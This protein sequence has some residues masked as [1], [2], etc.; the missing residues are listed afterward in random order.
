[1][2]RVPSRSAAVA[3]SR[4]QTVTAAARDA[5]E[6]SAHAR[7]RRRQQWRHV[8]RPPEIAPDVEAILRARLVR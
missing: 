3:L 2:P 6:R 7:L 5:C 1:M 4:A 8:R